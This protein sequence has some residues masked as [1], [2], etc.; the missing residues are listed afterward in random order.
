M[1]ELIK[2]V[3]IEE[4]NLNEDIIIFLKILDEH[5]AENITYIDLN[6]MSAVANEVIIATALSEIHSKSLLKNIIKIL[7]NNYKIKPRR[8]EGG[9]KGKWIVLDFTDMMLHI[10]VPEIRELYNL[11]DLWPDG[12]IYR[13]KTDK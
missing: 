1:E 9:N 2:S 6:E 5:K 7:R 12:K 4:S 3:S 11:E 10:M 8:E 13:I